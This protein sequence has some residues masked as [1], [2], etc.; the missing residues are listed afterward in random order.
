MSLEFDKNPFDGNKKML[1]HLD[2][3]NEYFKTGDTF[4][5]VMEINL[6]DIC[7][8]KCTYCFCDHRK[9]HT[10]TTDKVLAFLD[11]FKRLGGKAITFSGGGEPTRHKDFLKIMDHT[12]NLGLDVGL[13]TNGVFKESKIDE[14]CKEIGEKCNW[15]RISL[16]STDRQKYKEIK[17]VDV[18]HL[19]LKAIKRFRGCKAKVGLNTNVSAQ[20]TVADVDHMIKSL[21]HG[22]D[23]I[24][25]R[26][27]LP[28]YFYD[29][30]IEVNDEVWEYLKQYN[31]NKQ[32]IQSYDKYVDL[33][34]GNSVFPFQTC[35]GHYFSPIL[36]ANGAVK[37]CLY[38]P[39]DENLTFGN[40]NDKPLEDIW[41]S[42]QRQKAISYVRE[43][44][45]HNKCQMCCKLTEVNKFIDF[46]KYPDKKLDLNFI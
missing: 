23:Y 27:V 33:K 2:R 14:M 43:M 46:I 40:L 36:D 20:N 11:D 7:N 38:H 12:Y 6:T 41:K 17:Q 15:V 10:L 26:P 13:I 18:L 1:C 16:D 8:L 32:I 19:V 44:T 34:N 29:E 4:P 24:Q 22:V 9:T 45:Y 21:I 25:F 39:G 37:V 28:R 5:I 31:G 30:K 3:V 42:E 35:E